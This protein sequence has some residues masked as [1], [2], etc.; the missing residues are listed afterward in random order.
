MQDL[1]DMQDEFKAH[2]YQVT[3]WPRKWEAY[4]RNHDCDWS[5]V[6]VSDEDNSSIP[7]K[8]GV[9]SL[10]L[11]PDI[12]CHPYC[13]HMM[14]IGKAKSLKTRFNDYLNEKKRRSGR[15]KLY[16]L[17]N[18]YYKYTWYCYISAYIDDIGD[19]EDSLISAFIP[20][21]NTQVPTD[22]SPAKNAF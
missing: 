18:K 2:T 1:I 3:M 22:I 6:K 15:P 12:A 4:D 17:L 10:I 13:S 11:K 9:Y 20:P 8:P 21:C 16:R 7:D 19:I 14:Y 5:T